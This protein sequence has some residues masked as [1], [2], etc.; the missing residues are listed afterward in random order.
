MATTSPDGLISPD[1]SD[2]YD[3]TSDMAAMQASTQAALVNRASKSGS[4]SQMLNASGVQT[5]T[6]WYNTS[7]DRLYRYNGTGWD[8]V[9]PAPSVEELYTYSGGTSSLSSLTLVL[10]RRG[11]WVE[12]AGSLSL[13]SSWS[14]GNKKTIISSGGIPSAWRPPG[15]RVIPATLSSTSIHRGGDLVFNSTGSVVFGMSDTPPTSTAMMF[16][17]VYLLDS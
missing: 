16:S 3:L 13:D 9:A 10:R 14:Q 11:V 12:V 17:G 2:P 5:G 6:L 1:A 15:G 4:N 7:E 8:G